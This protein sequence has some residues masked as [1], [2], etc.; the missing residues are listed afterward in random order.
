MAELRYSIR[1]FSVC[2]KFRSDLFLVRTDRAKYLL[3]AKTA[4][5]HPDGAFV[6][7]AADL[8][9][10]TASNSLLSR[11]TGAAKSTVRSWR[12]ARRMPPLHVLRQ[13]GYELQRRGAECFSFNAS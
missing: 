7:R 2:L 13:L 10:M 9:F 12:R 1:T 6:T 5:R 11:A 3:E 8:L 4:M